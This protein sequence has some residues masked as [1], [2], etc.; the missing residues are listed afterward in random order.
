[1]FSAQSNLVTWN[2]NFGISFN[3][4]NKIHYARSNLDY[5]PLEKSNDLKKAILEL[6]NIVQHYQQ[7]A[8]EHWP[9]LNSL[10]EV[11]NLPL[12]VQQQWA[13]DIICQ[14]GTVPLLSQ[15]HQQAIAPFKHAYNQAQQTIIQMIDLGIII[16]GPPIKKQTLSEKQKTI[17][18]FNQLI[19]IYNDWALDHP[20]IAFPVTNQDLVD[21]T[22]TESKFWNSIFNPGV[23]LHEPLP[24]RL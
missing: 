3:D 13:Q 17:R 15:S 20:D 4:W 9:A 2:Q 12:A 23:L 11:A 10:D 19:E 7:H 18:N 24:N 22:H 8:P 6:P 21:K 1:V 5:L 16:N 14:E